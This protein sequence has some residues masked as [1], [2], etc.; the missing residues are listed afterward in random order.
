ME[1]LQLRYFYESAKNESFSR[2]AQKYM[3]PTTSVSASVK[4]LEEEL[5]CTLFDRFPNRILLNESGRRLEGSLRVVFRELEQ[6]TASLSSAA[7]GSHE[8]RMLVRAMRGSI[9]DRIIEYKAKHPHI[10]F[11]T[12]FDFSATDVENYDMIIDDHPE[13]YADYENFEIVSTRVLLKIASSNPLAGR[14][15]T[16][17]Q[18]KNQ[19]FLSMGEDSSMHAILIGACK[20]AG[21]T[22]NIVVQTNDTQCYLRCLEAGIGIG[23]G[24]DDPREYSDKVSFLTVTDFDCRQTVYGFYRKENAHGSVEHFL[25]FLKSRGV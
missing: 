5:G 24:R 15:L 7:S 13:K 18:L 19:P 1:L 23:M 22:P 10:S 9:T 8:I 12:V 2:T 4:R 16:L 20:R 3:V 25:R 21:F 6:V 17:A 11:R 14:R